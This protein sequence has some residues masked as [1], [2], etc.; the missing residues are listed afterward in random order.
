MA[1]ASSSSVLSSP[2]MR[3]AHRAVRRPENMQRIIPADAGSTR[4]CVSP[5]CGM[6]DRPRGCG[7]HLVFSFFYRRETRIIP[8]DAGSTLLFEEDGL[9][10]E[11]HPRG[12]GEHRSSSSRYQR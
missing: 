6:K 7:E 5:I 9:V 11:D 1:S 4:S 8:A 2:R 12:C 3:G 10:H